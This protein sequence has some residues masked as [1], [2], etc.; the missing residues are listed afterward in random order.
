MII[1]EQRG[2]FLRNKDD[3]GMSNCCIS[4]GYLKIAIVKI[5]RLYHY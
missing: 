3:Y 4:F 1:M 5:F 2:D